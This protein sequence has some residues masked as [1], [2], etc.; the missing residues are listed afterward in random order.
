MYSILSPRVNMENASLLDIIA[1]ASILIY[2]FKGYFKGFTREFFALVGLFGSIYIALVYSKP[3]G[4]WLNSHLLHMSNSSLASLV[5][6]VA[7]LVLGWLLT[8]G[9]GVALD[10]F[11][12]SKGLGL[13][14]KLFGFILGGIKPLVAIAF[15]IHIFTS[16][17]MVGN[18]INDSIKNSITYPYFEK[19]ISSLFKKDPTVL[20]DKVKKAAS[21]A[22]K[23]DQE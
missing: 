6:S 20:F 21:K 15:L 10:K 9:M 3:L 11:F 4:A 2:G 22:K 19:T 16:L 17:P 8:R 1:L 13:I 14:N 12:N 7:I 18:S 5:T 23:V